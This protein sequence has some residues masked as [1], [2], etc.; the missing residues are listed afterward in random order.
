MLRVGILVSLLVLFVAPLV[1][2]DDPPKDTATAAKTREKSK[3]KITQT[4]KDTPLKEILDDI[5]EATGG[6]QDGLKF[7]IDTKSGVSQN[8]KFSYKC[9]D[10]PA[11]EVLSEI[12]EMRK[13]GWYVISKE[14]DAYEGLIKVRVGDE[15][16]YEGVSGAGSGSGSTS[17]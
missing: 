5:K 11:A 13:W 6:D 14:K 1:L 16:G 9:K 7:Q 15:R 8:S 4:W 3:K 17:K 12:L 2:A 10:K